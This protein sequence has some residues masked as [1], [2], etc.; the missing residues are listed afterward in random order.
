M[1]QINA[2]SNLGI[3]SEY[4]TLSST[5]IFADS[6]SDMTVVLVIPSSNPLNKLGVTI[7]TSSPYRPIKKIFAV[8]ASVTSD[9]PFIQRMSWNP[10]DFALLMATIDER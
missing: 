1:E 2:S 7:S 3:S 5:L 10:S 8:E 9:S 6:N 4:T